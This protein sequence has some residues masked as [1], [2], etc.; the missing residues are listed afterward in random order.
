MK[1]E[2]EIK[3]T[4]AFWQRVF[5]KDKLIPLLIFIPLVLLIGII[6]PKFF[7]WNNLQNI[8]MQVSNVGI[9]ALGAMFVITSGGLDFTAGD[10]VSLAGV[11]AA[12]MFVSSG[13]NNLVTILAGIFMGA[14]MGAFNGLI[15]TKMK[16]QPF[17][18]TLSVMTIIK[19]F[20]LFISE[21]AIIHMDVAG[22]TFT[23]IGQGIIPF[24]GDLGHMA[25]GE[26]HGI[27]IAFLIFLGV[28]VIAYLL[29]HRTKF[30]QALFAMGGNEE[31]ARLAGVR[32]DFY[33]FLV[34]VFA[35][36]CTGMGAIV[37][38]ARVA[39]IG[40][41]LGGTTLLMDVVAAAV[42]G[43]T[44]VSGGRCNVFG[45]V[46]GSFIIICITSALIYLKIDTN[47]QDV[48]KGVIIFVALCIDMAVKT[49]NRRGGRKL[50]NPATQKAA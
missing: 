25:D 47:W 1:S 16:I 37:T 9:I 49:I 17:I 33:R 28:A 42:I 6:N 21:G 27:P 5:T 22:A 8:M 23:Q 32:V 46:I 24:P 2:Y 41:S 26:L 38:L 50:L 19:G 35:G 39:S 10:G 36:M 34:Y 30:G 48:V 15:I 43:G 4:G 20:L 11:F 7:Q 29:L 13:M 12:T 18:T 14:V 3:N 31:A 40:I 45:V 44:S